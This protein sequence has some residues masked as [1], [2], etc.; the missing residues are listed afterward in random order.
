MAVVTTVRATLK[1]D[2]SLKVRA[3]HDIVPE[4]KQL[5]ELSANSMWVLYL[6]VYFVAA[7]GI[8]NTQRMNALER[9]REFGVLLA[10]GT[11]P[12]RLARQVVAES[13]L[14]CA[15][16]GVLG[17]LLGTAA[18]AWH[19]YNGLDWRA[20]APG[21]EGEFTYMGVT[22]DVMYFQLNPFD[23]VAPAAIILVVG[24][25]CGLWPAISSARLHVARA[26]AGRT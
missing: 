8:L 5:I 2:A 10:I 24:F 16:G 19:A 12:G 26:I 13:V 6:V 11:T 7:L 20:F 17:V 3:W 23:I 4:L 9:R 14:V 22:F 21:A 25:L 15:A 18:S 1:A